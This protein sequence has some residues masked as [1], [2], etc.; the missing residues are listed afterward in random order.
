MVLHELGEVRA[1]QDLGP[2]W[3][4][5]R[6]A[7]PTRRGDAHARALRDHLADLAV[8]LPTLLQRRAEASIHFWFAN[9]D[10]VRLRLF[11]SLPAAYAAWRAGDG[12]RALE[13]ALSRGHAHFLQLARRAQATYAQGGGDGAAAEAVLT[14][15]AAVCG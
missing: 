5:L 12:G 8:T 9:F 4:E 2:D 1:G 10:G 14:A 3:G 13:Q 7:L 6:L 11:P 15:D